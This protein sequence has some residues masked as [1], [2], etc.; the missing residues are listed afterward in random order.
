MDMPKL[1]S[2]V[3]MLSACGFPRPQDVSPGGNDAAPPSDPGGEVKGCTQ[4]TCRS[5]VLE[6]CDAAG[7]V[8]H[9][10]QCDLGCSSDGG[11]CNELAPSNGLGTALDQAPEHSAITLP[12]GTFIDADSGVVTAGAPIAVATTT[13][14]QPG[15]PMIRVLL[16]KAWT[17]HDVT[18]RGASPVAFVAS[19]E[20]EIRGVIDA[21]AD[22]DAG[23]PGALSCDPG[24]GA[25]GIAGPGKFERP[26]AGSS[27]GY[28]GFVWVINGHGGGGFGTPGGAGGQA[29]S[30]NPVGAAGVANGNA[31]LVPLRG[32]CWGGGGTGSEFQSPP[33]HRGA[34]G[35][36]IQLVSGRGIHVASGGGLHVGGGRGI[37]GALGTDAIPTTDPIYG[38]AGGGS[39]GG[40]LME[41]PSLTV[42]DGAMLLAA[43]GGG[44]GYGACSPAPDGGDA[45]PGAPAAP[46]GACPAD[47]HPAGNGGAGA[48]TAEGT[49]GGPSNISGTGSGGSGGGGLGR[50]RINTADGTYSAAPTALI[51][52]ATTT[53]MVG[54]R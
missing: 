50:I 22:G 9:T 52:G 28:P 42:D 49:P 7:T 27:P 29:V 54:R 33:L 15:G 30:D 11:R 41:A 2:L 14:M 34:G 37:A 21:S 4:T 25:G 40:I 38:P 51:R 24:A 46:G 6:V 19:D 18:I 35:G 12:G 17:I 53:G 39:G 8:E 32:G 43:G 31:E 48:T 20:I 1:M 3:I 5:D 26:V 23:G 10:E 36:A 16:A 13:V 47:V 45:E 44:G